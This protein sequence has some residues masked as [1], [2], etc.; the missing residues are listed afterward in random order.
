MATKD[1]SV[2][3]EVKVAKGRLILGVHGTDQEGK[4]REYD[5]IELTSLI[6]SNQ[7]IKLRMEIR[8]GE[9]SLVRTD[10]GESIGGLSPKYPKGPFGFLVAKSSEAQFKS[11]WVKVFKPSQAK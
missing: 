8:G 4:G 1:Y 6:P 11:V 2:T 3:F 10:T 9:F 5:K 7:W